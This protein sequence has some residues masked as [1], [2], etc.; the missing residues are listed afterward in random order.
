MAWLMNFPPVHD[1]LARVVPKRVVLRTVPGEVIDQR[2]NGKNEHDSGKQREQAAKIS[3]AISENNPARH[4]ARRIP[5]R[6]TMRDDS[7]V[8]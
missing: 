5:E 4:F 2:H 8:S 6:S 7:L 1:E 3:A